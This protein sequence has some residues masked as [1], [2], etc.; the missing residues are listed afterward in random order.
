MLNLAKEVHYGRNSLSV[1]AT[2]KQQNL[3]DLGHP[4]EV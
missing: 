2:K 3:M 4:E 1:S